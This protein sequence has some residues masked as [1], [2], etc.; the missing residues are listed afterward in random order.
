MDTTLV[1][2]WERK[3]QCNSNL[4]IYLELGL[5][6]TILLK[7]RY[8]LCSMRYALTEGEEVVRG[9]KSLAFGISEPGFIFFVG[10]EMEGGRKFVGMQDL[11]FNVDLRE[12]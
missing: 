3:G 9:S 12:V 8:A 7:I 2:F 11:T 1:F 4:A 6:L 10:G 5:S